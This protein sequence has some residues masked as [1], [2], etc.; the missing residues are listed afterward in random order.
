MY[1]DETCDWCSEPA[2]PGAPLEDHEDFLGHHVCW[3]WYL[4][5]ED[6][7]AAR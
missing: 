7:V 5:Y 6:R 2:E 3:Q 4:M 1:D